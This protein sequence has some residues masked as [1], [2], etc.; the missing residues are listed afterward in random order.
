MFQNHNEKPKTRLLNPVGLAVI[1]IL[2]MYVGAVIL[3]TI[4]K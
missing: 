3:I 1:I 4:F 2:T